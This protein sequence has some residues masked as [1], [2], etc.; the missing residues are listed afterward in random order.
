MSTDRSAQPPV[1]DKAAP[2]G[3]VSEMFRDLSIDGNGAG[4]PKNGRRTNR[5]ADPA[6][7]PP[8]EDRSL[9]ISSQDR[10]LRS[11]TINYDAQRMIG[12]GSFGVVF[13]AK[14]VETNEI[15]A[16]K[17]VLQDRRFKNRE[18]QIMRQ[19]QKQ[20]HPNIVTLKH[21]FVSKGSKQDDVY[22]NLVLEFVPETV[23]SVSKEY[24]RR[25]ETVPILITKL[26]MYQ[27]SRA[28][29][30][31]HGM[32][33]CHRDI[34]PQNLLV[35]P[36]KNTLKL[37]DFGS[38]KSLVP[39]EPNVAYICSRYYRAPELIFGSTDYTTAIDV[40]SQG[41]VLA[42]LLTG[43]PLFPGS[44]GVDQLVEIIKVL[45][46]PT[47]EELKAMNP[48]YQEFRFPQIRAHPWNGVFK[49]RTPPESIEL[50]GRMLAYVP[51]TRCKAIESCAH[52]FFDELRD[53]AA[54]QPDGSP[55]PDYFFQFTSEELVLCPSMGTVLVPPHKVAVSKLVSEAS[56]SGASA[57]GTEDN[58][59]PAFQQE[60]KLE[61]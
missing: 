41:C 18:L 60:V 19:L 34:K 25:K 5:R 43:S 10:D 37:C 57:S 33:I 30:H 24:G 23:Y 32:G 16:I 1:A 61:P 14:V 17:K 27:L 7:A 48:N 26:F 50:V 12:H 22:L 40:W 45:G 4:D 44:S 39:G 58:A 55:I 6:N 2:G 9:E 13:Q 46:T 31:I 51:E 42:E 36:A 15:V 35:N 11:D 28:L 52:S 38:A 3:E 56:P 21:F 54:S 53:P 29:G 47:K 8:T 59:P 20:P 49:P